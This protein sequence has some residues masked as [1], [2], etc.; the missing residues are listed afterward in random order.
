MKIGTL[1]Y[2]TDSGLGILAKSFFD[3]GVVNNVVV[4][5]H[6]HH[7]THLGW[8]P[9]GMP[10]V[11]IRHVSS[12]RPVREFCKAMDV[13]LFFETPFDW[14]LIEFCRKEGVKTVIM[15][16]HECMPANTSAVPDLWLCPSMLDYEWAQQKRGRL[17]YLPVPVNVQWRQRERAEVFVHNAGHGGLRGR[18]GTA[19]LLQ[20]LQYV[21]S[22]A[23][24]LI[25]SQKRIDFDFS[26]LFPETAHITDD[27]YIGWNNKQQRMTYFAGTVSHDCLLRNGDV[28]VFPEKF[29][30]LSL[31]LQEARAAGMLVM[32]GDRFPMNQWLPC[33]PLIPVAGYHKERISG[34]YSEYNCAEFDPKTIAAKIDEWYCRDINQHSLDGKE[35]AEQNRWE[36]MKSEYMSVLGSL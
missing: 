7:K 35:W 8:Y 9:L 17:V 11:G 19:E 20:S 22:P 21:K 30:G 14:S 23:K 28:F 15:P 10:V 3:A 2:A 6:A 13:M 24:F 32:C 31:P 18:N 12:S 34:A 25:R 1:C 27:A 16:M 36:K 26:K 5:E 29:N 4:V 33:D